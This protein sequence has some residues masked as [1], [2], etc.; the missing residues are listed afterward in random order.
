MPTLEESY[1]GEIK[2]RTKRTVLPPE[3][4]KPQEVN[5]NSLT[6]SRGYWLFSYNMTHFP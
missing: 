3:L 4:V 1:T 6:A 2:Y 5:S